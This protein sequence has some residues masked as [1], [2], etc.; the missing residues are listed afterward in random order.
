MAM[1]TDNLYLASKKCL[2]PIINSMLGFVLVLTV[3][4][5]IGCNNV[6][7]KN[8]TPDTA[9]VA[10]SKPAPSKPVII[11]P[12]ARWEPL[13]YDSTKKY[14]YLTFDDGPQHGTMGCFDTCKRWGVKAS[15]F[16]VGSH[17]RGK[18]DGMQIAGMIRNSYPMFL[19]A[20]HSNTHAAAGYHRFYRQVGKTGADFAIA[21]EQ[22]QVPYKIARLPGNSAWVRAGELQ[23]SPLVKQVT[24]L[25]DSA[26]YNVFGWDVEWN[27]NHKN[28]KPIQ[29][30]EKLTAEVDSAFTRNKTHVKNHLVILTH[31]RMFQRPEDAAVL[32]AFIQLLKQNPAYVF[33]TVDHYPGI[34]P[35]VYQSF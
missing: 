34:K 24:A 29:S 28:A 30:P 21:Q 8:D 20:N 4:S 31:D 22:L 27:F 7:T 14:I 11:N 26:G 32:S 9:T 10:K 18:S 19:L 35:P 23:A 5:I 15:F 33:E 13:V 12:L 17:A 3:N 16:M 25:L 6:S 2:M 1:K